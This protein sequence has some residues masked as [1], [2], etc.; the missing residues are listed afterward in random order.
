MPPSRNFRRAEE[1]VF[2]G[3]IVS[4]INPKTTKVTKDVASTTTLSP[5][6]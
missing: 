6:N 1:N 3:I 2:A 4:E 5:G